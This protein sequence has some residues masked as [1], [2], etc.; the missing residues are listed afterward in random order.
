MRTN[1]GKTMYQ[2]AIDLFPVNRSLTGDGVR[3]TLEYFKSVIPELKIENVPTGYE[4]FDWTVP[5]EWNIREGFIENRTGEKIVDFKQNNLHIVG[6]STPVNEWMDREELEKHLYSLPA[7][8]D[9]IPYVTSYYAENWGFCLT[10]QQRKKI[11]DGNYHVVI[12]SE[13]KK[14][15]LNYGE[16]ILP[17]D[18]AEEVLLS[19]Y[20]CHPSMANNELSGPVVMLAL[21]QWLSSLS[22]RRYTYRFIFIPETIGSIVYL[23]KNMD[24][25]KKK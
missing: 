8:P 10:E 16:L 22:D 5:Q 17:G 11:P 2:W 9:A 14:G 24:H 18:S 3:E 21:A 1:I 6:Y 13:L 4:A 25:L 15:L 23:S 20:I 12:D 19:T 7:Q